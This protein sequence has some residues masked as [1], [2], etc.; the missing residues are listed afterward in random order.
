MTSQRQAWR[1]VSTAAESSSDPQSIDALDAEIRT[2]ARQMNVQTYRLLVLVRELDDRM[3]WQKWSMRNCAEWLAWR[4]DLSLSAAREKVRVAH[5]LRELPA[6]AAAF[7]AGRLSYSKVRALTRVVEYHDEESL[8]AYALQV[9]A[10]QVEERC[11]EIR[12]ASPDE[13]AVGAWRAWERRSLTVARDPARGTMKITV[14]VPMED[15]EVIVN[16]VE[17]VADAA[18][19]AIGLEFAAAR[20]LE[21]VRDSDAQPSAANGWR[22][23]RADALLAIAKASLAGESAAA[24]HGADGAGVAAC[25]AADHY[26]VVVHVDDSALRGGVGRSDLPIDTVRR[27]ACDGSLVTVVEDERGTPLDVGRKQRTVSTPLKRALWSRDR[28]CTFPGCRNTRYVDAHHIRHWADG[29]DTSLENL[30]LLCSHHHRALHEGRFAVRHDEHGA[31]YFRRPD[32][33]AIPKAGYRLDDMLDD[34]VDD[35]ADRPGEPSAEGFVIS[36]GAERNPSAEGFAPAARYDR[37]PSAEVREPAAVYVLR[38]ERPARAA[39][40]ARPTT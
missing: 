32:G 36:A 18:D 29:G 30:T 12:N 10:E 5:A 11:R 39:T 7:A 37:D 27:L 17:R 15:G 8:L 13:S 38:R 4:C 19:A 21:R 26:Q 14:E 3:G 25:A 23:Q 33:R 22:A 20:K 31:I 1:A 34:F 6:I 2:L 35:G 28:G 16:A 24:A 9:S 40:V